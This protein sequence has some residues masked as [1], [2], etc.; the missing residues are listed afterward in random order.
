[1]YKKQE[2]IKFGPTKIMKEPA[3]WHKFCPKYTKKNSLDLRERN[4]MNPQNAS[5]TVNCINFA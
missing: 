4:D 2:T 5:C 1:M 3:C